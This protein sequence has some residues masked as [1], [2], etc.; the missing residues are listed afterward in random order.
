MKRTVFFWQVIGFL[1]TAIG[2]TLLHFIY[3]WSNESVFIAPFSG[4]NESTWEHMK[5]LYWPLFIYALYER[6]YFKERKNYWCIK[7]W[8]ILSGLISIPV[9]FY[10]LNGAFGKTPDWINITI[11]FIS[12]ATAFI[13]ETH[14]FKQ[15]SYR[16]RWE[17]VAFIAICFIGALFIIFTFFTPK[18]P[19]FQDPINGTFGV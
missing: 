12:A 6:R 1:F 7:L 19:L 2:G 14:S 5:L 16:C 9:L 8:G 18:I 4:I 17:R 13:L 15:D 3:D 11:F 10:T